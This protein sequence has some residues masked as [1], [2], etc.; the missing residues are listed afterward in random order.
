MNKLGAYGEVLAA[1]YLRDLGH[2]IVTTNFRCHLGEIDII[3]VDGDT[4]VFTEVKTRIS[5]FIPAVESVNLTKQRKIMLTARV[6]AASYR[7]KYLKFRYDII[8]VYM[9]D[10]FT[11]EKLVLH[12]NA[13]GRSVFLKGRFAWNIRAQETI[14]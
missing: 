8:E 7:V 12:K 11:L 2:I 13:F 14:L 4:M 5:R 9:K 1:R 3:S 10:E 6:Y